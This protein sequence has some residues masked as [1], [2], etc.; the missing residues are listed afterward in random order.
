LVTGWGRGGSGGPMPPSEEEM[1]WAPRNIFIKG[2]FRDTA[3]H[4]Y[5]AAR[6][7][8][9]QQ[10]WGQFLWMGLQAIEKYLK[11]IILFDDGDTRRLN[12]N[13]VKAL[14]Q[15]EGIE[16]LGM[17]VSDRAKEFIVYLGGQGENRYFT[18]P[19]YV[20]GKELFQL[21]H[22][23]WQIRRY[24]TDYFLPLDHPVLIDRQKARLEEVH[25]GR[26]NDWATFRLEK[27]GYLE[28][29]LDGGK[30]P[31]QRSAL[32]WKNFYFGGRNRKTIYSRCMERGTLSSNLIHP[33]ILD[34]AKTRVKLS[35][36]VIEEMG[37]R[38]R[39]NES[40]K[41]DN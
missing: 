26:N 41:Q 11:A 39:E 28:T 25:I 13:I 9:R 33:E 14:K 21:D 34:W 23:V 36:A 40:W 15:A 1:I 35:K 17:K 20:K 30:H 37:R 10:L 22:T 38:L 2:S 32:I 4:D 27:Q 8:H 18:W 31:I 16:R 24:C 29:V 5:I 7:L 6:V 12:H 3:D 19:R